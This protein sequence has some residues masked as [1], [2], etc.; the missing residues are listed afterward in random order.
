MERPAAVQG[1]I[2]ATH[3]HSTI[4]ARF[5]GWSNVLT[6]VEYIEGLE[7]EN[8]ALKAR[9]ELV[10]EEYHTVVQTAINLIVA[11][12]GEAGLREQFEKNG[13]GHLLK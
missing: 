8:E 11:A 13:V 9:N 12:G 3:E 2:D 6:I 1:F 10:E 7:A 5:V 4:G